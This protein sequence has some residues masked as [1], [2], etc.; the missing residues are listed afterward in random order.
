MIHRVRYNPFI[1]AANIICYS[2]QDNVTIIFSPYY[3]VLICHLVFVFIYVED[4][5]FCHDQSAVD[6]IWR[7]PQ[8]IM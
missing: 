3:E 7:F 1:S 2:V 4:G 5:H 6:A 8:P